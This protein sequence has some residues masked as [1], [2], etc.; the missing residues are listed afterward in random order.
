MVT[1]LLLLE[2]LQPQV[3]A[4]GRPFS[5]G[6]GGWALRSAQTVGGTASC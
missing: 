6:G 5:L 1:A 2:A 4:E 3:F